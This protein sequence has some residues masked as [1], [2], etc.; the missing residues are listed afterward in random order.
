M[1]R[2]VVKRVLLA[3]L[4][5]FIIAA[6][7]FFAMNAIPG[8]PFASEKAKDPAVEAMLM[9][10]FHLDKPVGEQF[11]IYLGNLAHGD[12]GISLKT[13]REISDVISESFS[14]SA[15][16]AACCPAGA[17]HRAGAGIGGGALPRP[18]AGPRDHLCDHVVCFGAQLHSGHH[19]A[20]GLLPAAAMGGRVVAQ[21]SQLRAAGDRAGALS[22]GLYHPV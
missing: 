9:Q 7:T 1:L 3:I 21:Q 17:R 14:V 12:F 20:A 22:H 18:L 15:T 4:T 10:R 19:S 6:I 13:G 11:L 5:V 2:Y 16:L 8:G